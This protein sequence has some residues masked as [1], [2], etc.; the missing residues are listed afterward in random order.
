MTSTDLLTKYENIAGMSFQMVQAARMSDW[1]GLSRLEKQCASEAR[2]IVAGV[3]MLSSASRERKI[4]LIKQILAN[5][6]AIRD[7]TQSWMN[8]IPGSKPRQ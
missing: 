6:R 8:Q 4:D 2:G 1:D 7:V 5:D 3:P